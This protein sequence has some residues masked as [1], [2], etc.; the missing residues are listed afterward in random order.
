MV[1][2]VLQTPE[3][4]KALALHGRGKLQEAERAYL[5]ILR[6]NPREDRAL[7]LL[8]VLALQ[9][10]QSQRGTDLIRRAI[11]LNPS[12][13]LAHRDLGNALLQ[14]GNPQEALA[15]LDQA[16]ALKPDQADVLDNRG[17]ALRMLNRPGEALQ[18]HDRALALA[19]DVALTHVNRGSALAAMNRIAQALESFDRAIALDP[20]SALAHANRGGALHRLERFEEALQGHDRA[21]ALAPNLAPAHVS[22]GQTLAELGDYDRALAAYERALVLDSQSLEAMFGRATTLLIM[23]RFPEGWRAYEA[24]RGRVGADAFHAAGRLQWTGKENIAGKTLFIEAEQGLGD[25]IQFCRYARRAADL[26]AQVILTARDSQVRLLHGLDPRIQVLPE[27]ERP[28]AFDYHIPLMSLPM[29]FGAGDFA[30]ETPYLHAQPDRITQWR[31]RIGN[32]GFKIGICW[33]GGRVNTA[34]AFPLP[35]LAGIAAHPQ[36][37]LISLQ[38]GEGCE[39]LDMCPFPVETLGSDYDAGPDGFLDAAAVMQAVD[40]VIACDTALAHLAGALARPVWVALKYA[41]DWRY[42]LGRQDS[43]W[44]P[45]MR[46]FRQRRPGDWT[47]AFAGMEAWIDAILAGTPLNSSWRR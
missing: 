36:V 22:R 46:L 26:G 10:G 2:P 16:L 15:S 18:S 42:L 4:H 29:A 1:A 31:N 19:P 3:L 32:H 35:L 28:Q 8:G 20:A 25:M 33:Q 21:I 45:S 6:Q 43:V 12:R 23:G 17:T 41:P 27:K 44:Y 47:G 39:Q 9:L 30:A 40:L 7:H 24:R 14:A 13:P 34:R 38:I 5:K 37:R 11:G